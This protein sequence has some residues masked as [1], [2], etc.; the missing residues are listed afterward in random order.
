M[1]LEGTQ[2]SD[3]APSIHTQQSLVNSKARELYS[4]LLYT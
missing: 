3:T 2:R 4:R 1:T